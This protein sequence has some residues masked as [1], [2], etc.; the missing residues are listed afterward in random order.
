MNIHVSVFPSRGPNELHLPQDSCP[1]PW[2]WRCISLAGV[3]ASW[4]SCHSGS[5]SL[6]HT[7]GTAWCGITVCVTAFLL[8]AAQDTLTLT[9]RSGHC[10]VQQLTGVFTQGGACYGPAL[11]WW[12]VSLGQFLS[13]VG[14]SPPTWQWHKNPLRLDLHTQMHEDSWSS[15]CN[16]HDSV[17]SFLGDCCV[18]T[19]H[20][21]PFMLHLFEMD[22]K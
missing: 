22:F 3:S 20:T 1:K 14:V 18:Y 13:P 11:I 8:A 7:L 9:L 17:M 6:V 15:M 5:R 2:L 19:L 10:H 16:C 4:H 21:F 12:R